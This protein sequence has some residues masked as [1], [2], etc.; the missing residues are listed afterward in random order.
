MQNADD[1]EI[2][3]V[4]TETQEDQQFE[5]DKSYI[6]DQAPT[7]TFRYKMFRIK[8]NA[9]ADYPGLID[10]DLTLANIGGQPPDLEELQGWVEL[11][12][13]MEHFFVIEKEIYIRDEYG[14]I[15]LDKKG[16][17]KKVLARVLDQNFDS[18]IALIRSIIKFPLNASRAIG[19]DREA[20]LDKTEFLSKDIRRFKGEQN[21][22]A[23]GVGGG[24]Q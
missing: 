15:E 7:D 11:Q 22:R 21:S 6:S 19:K 8:P 3:A 2:E 9:D 14:R 24:K 17:P 1:N 5:R 13:L 20:V 16:N 10:K 4:Q 12:V 23:F 18:S